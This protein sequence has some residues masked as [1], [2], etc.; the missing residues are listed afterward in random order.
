MRFWA[1]ALLWLPAS[2]V[3]LSVARGFSVAP[4][5]LAM[6]LASLAGL[7]SCGLP[8]AFACRRIHRTGAR[9]AA[10]G[11]FAVLAPA[12]VLMILIAGL[13]GPWAVIVAAMIGSAPAWIVYALTRP[14]A[15]STR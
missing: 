6:T 9:G 1:A 2:M 7:A 11:S 15:R 13:L 5:G 12:T 4:G 10:W 3:V 14:F 8:L